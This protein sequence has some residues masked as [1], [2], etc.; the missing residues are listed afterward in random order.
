M[1]PYLRDEMS[2]LYTSDA[3]FVTPLKANQI[4]TRYQRALARVC[5]GAH[6]TFHE[7]RHYAAS[8]MI[9]LGIPVK[10]IAD[11]LGH[12]TE[13]MVNRV[14]GHIMRDKKDQFFERLETYYSDTFKRYL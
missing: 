5:P 2:R 8:V 6:Y 9:M 12:E 3:V 10:Y 14:Y 11:M 1:I 7:L 4:Y 13:E